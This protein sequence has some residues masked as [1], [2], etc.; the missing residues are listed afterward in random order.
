V[1]AILEV[2]G[3]QHRAEPGRVIKTQKLPV[4]V[5]AEVVLEQVLAI[6]DGEKLRVGTPYLSGAR[7]LGRVLQQGRD[8]KVRVFKYKPKKHYRRTRGHRQ[9]FTV[10]QITSI[11]IEPLADI[12]PKRRRSK[13]A[14]AAE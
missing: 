3:H 2:G 11:A 9:P 5:G 13:K 8:R 10:V 6:H 1:Y 14:S 12:K 4:P 7:V